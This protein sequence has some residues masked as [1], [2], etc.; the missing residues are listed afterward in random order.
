MIKYNIYIQLQAQ[1]ERRSGTCRIDW[2]SNI[3]FVCDFAREQFRCTPIGIVCA[4]TASIYILNIYFLF[5]FVCIFQSTPWTARLL[6]PV[7]SRM[8][9]TCVFKHIQYFLSWRR[10]ISEMT[11]QSRFYFVDNG[12]N[13]HYFDCNMSNRHTIKLRRIRWHDAD[14][15]TF[16]F[17][18]IFKYDKIWNIWNNKIIKL[19][20]NRTTHDIIRLAL[21]TVLFHAHNRDFGKIAKQN[22]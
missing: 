11:R 12:R 7:L 22:N 15:D 13:A 16:Y 17:L 5:L 20:V 8:R 4:P 14:T 18:Y 3:E 21:I 19:N 10:T 1:K 2:H 6:M 9:Q